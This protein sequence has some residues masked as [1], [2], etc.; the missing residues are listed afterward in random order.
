MPDDSEVERSGPGR[1]P[2]SCEFALEEAQPPFAETGA[3]DGDPL[4]IMTLAGGGWTYLTISRIRLLKG[5][6]HNP[7]VGVVVKPRD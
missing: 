4:G 3:R 7:Q 6:G 5:K 2:S 1:L